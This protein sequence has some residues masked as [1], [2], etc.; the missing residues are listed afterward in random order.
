MLV[1]GL[2]HFL[3]FHIMGIMIPIDFHIFQRGCFTT[4]QNGLWGIPRPKWLVIF[5]EVE[6][7]DSMQL[8]FSEC[9]GCW[10]LRAWGVSRMLPGLDGSLYGCCETY[11]VDCT[12]PG[13]LA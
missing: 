6:D 10:R 11:F 13:N 3:F 12:R 7:Y 9:E 2:E 4:N 8:T 5:R 1:G